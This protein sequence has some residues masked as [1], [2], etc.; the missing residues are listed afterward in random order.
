M[1]IE[2]IPLTFEVHNTVV[3][4]PA[5]I[6][7]LCHNEPFILVWPHRMLAHGVGQ[8]FGTVAYV[9]VSKVIVAVI[10]ESKRALGLATGQ[11]LKTVH[12]KH[13]KLTV[14]PLDG[15]LRSIISEFLH[16]VLEFGTASCPPEYVSIAIGGLKNARIDTVNALDGFRLR[17]ERSFGTIG[18]SHTDAETSHASGRSGW[19]IE[20]VFPAALYAVGCP[21]GI[22]VGSYPRHFVLGD[23]NAMIGPIGKILRGEHVVV[24]HAEP[25]LT[26]S[27]WGQDIMRRVKI[28]LTIK[29][30]SRRVGGELITNN[31]V[32]S[33]QPATV[34]HQQGESRE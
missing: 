24:L 3:I 13:L 17:D 28:N 1:V 7:M 34:E 2:Q 18:Y 30:A 20:I 22:G 19:K 26:L 32:L 12:S 11:A 10:L 25:V 6:G 8:D 16:I 9:R 33:H 21:H 14:T 23:D 5:A 31:R 29:Y 4:G 15:F 27:F